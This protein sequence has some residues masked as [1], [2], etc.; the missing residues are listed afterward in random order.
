MKLVISK[1]TLTVISASF[2]E[3]LKYNFY[4]YFK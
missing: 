2:P 4:I 1:M 3:I